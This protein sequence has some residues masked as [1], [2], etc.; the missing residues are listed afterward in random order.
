MNDASN[1]FFFLCHLESI[2]VKSVPARRSFYRKSLGFKHVSFV[3]FVFVEAN[4]K[5][6]V[7]GY[8]LSWSSFEGRITRIFASSYAGFCR[9]GDVLA[10]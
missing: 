3:E 5:W 9:F 2:I 7:S 1:A 8:L 6:G 4:E 10:E